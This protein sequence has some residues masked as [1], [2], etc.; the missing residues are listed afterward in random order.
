M[1][2]RVLAASVSFRAAFSCGY[3]WV[4]LKRFGDRMAG[5]M[6]RRKM[7]ADMSVS[8]ISSVL[9][10]LRHSVRN[11]A[12]TCFI[13]SGK[14][15]HELNTRP[16]TKCNIWTNSSRFAFLIEKSQIIIFLLIFFFN[17]V[18]LVYLKA[19]GIGDLGRIDLEIVIRVYNG[20]DAICE[21]ETQVVLADEL[22]VGLHGFG[23]ERVASERERRVFE[24]EYLGEHQVAQKLGLH[25]QFVR[26]FYERRRQVVFCPHVQV[27]LQ[28]HH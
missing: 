9:P 7:L 21:C 15:I 26:D 5:Q 3:S 2:W 12:N 6:K 19:G 4:R 14:L 17:S 24:R 11:L 27:R 16:H 10:C 23:S 1:V 13:S 8:H 18:Q 25:V 20:S 22:H 28:R